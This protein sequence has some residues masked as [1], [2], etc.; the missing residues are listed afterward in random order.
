V[1]TGAMNIASQA[2]WSAMQFDDDLNQLPL[3]SYAVLD[4]FGSRPVWRNLDV[5]VAVEN[6]FNRGVEVSATPVVTLGQPRVFRVGVR[7]R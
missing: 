5:T 1:Y 3:A 4:L 2:R 6:L 7:Y